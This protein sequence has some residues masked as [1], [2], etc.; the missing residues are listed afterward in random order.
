MVKRNFLLLGIFYVLILVSLLA[1]S[2]TQMDLNLTLSKSSVFQSWQRFFIQIGY[3]QRPLSTIIFLTI[4]SLLFLFYFLILRLVKIG[5]ISQKQT[6]WFIGASVV[7]LFFSYPA[8]S[9]DLFNYMFDARIFTHYQ[10]N[11]HHFKALDFPQDPWIRFM[12]WTHREYPYGPSWLI[13]TI[14]LS[15]LGFDKFLP[16]LFNFKVLMTGAYIGTVY[17][18]H[19]ILTKIKP[20]ESLFGTAFFALNPLILIES[21]VSAHHDIVMMF[22]ALSSFYLLLLR[23]KFYSFISIVAS[24]GIKYV[25]AFLFPVW[26]F[27]FRPKLAFIFS[28]LGFIYVA[29]QMEIQPWYFIW[30]LSFIALIPKERLLIFLAFGFSLGLL[31]RY[32]PFLYLGHWNDP[33]PQIKILVTTIPLVL[34]FFIFLFV[35][36]NEKISGKNS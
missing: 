26:L 12:H 35:K 30:V 17:L 4:I 9:H 16:T 36:L 31:L 8:F 25:T 29:R 32:A 23:K 1:Y 21:L 7:I 18:V 28:L 14:P 20:E 2:F 5:Q 10:L 34:S 3:F 11:P 24:I 6:W 27:G 13:L 19:K 15:Y 33:A 22:F